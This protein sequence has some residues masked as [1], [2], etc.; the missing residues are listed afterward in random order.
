MEKNWRD[1]ELSEAGQ[2]LPPPHPHP[3]RRAEG[4]EMG[5]HP[6][7]PRLHHP[8]SSPEK[9]VTLW[10]KQLKARQARTWN[11]CRGACTWTDTKY[12]ETLRDSTQL[13]IH[14]AKCGQDTERPRT[15]LPFP[16]CR[17][18]GGSRVLAGPL[19]AASPSG[20]PPNPQTRPTPGRSPRSCSCSPRYTLSVTLLWPLVSAYR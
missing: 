8:V 5:G 7:L 3:Q 17:G 9:E 6:S 11:P 20:G 16:R 18:A 10:A 19:Q 13:H 15:R 12:R 14:G 2:A 1:R 4:Q